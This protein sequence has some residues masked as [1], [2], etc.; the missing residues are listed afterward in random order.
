MCVI[1]FYIRL[2][3]QS[4]YLSFRCRQRSHLLAVEVLKP[5]TGLDTRAATLDRKT[6]RRRITRNFGKSHKVQCFNILIQFRNNEA[7][8][9][10][11]KAIVCPEQSYRSSF[12]NDYSSPQ[13]MTFTK[14]KK[15]ILAL[16]KPKE[17]GIL[18]LVGCHPCISPSRGHRF[19]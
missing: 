16:E 17:T 15:R 10:F 9:H 3:L 14:C 18:S 7:Q 13:N 4:Y 1:N 11:R 5:G 19:H 12:E 2:V 6:F 8:P